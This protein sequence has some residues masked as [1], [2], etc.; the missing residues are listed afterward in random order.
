MLCGCEGAQ[1]AQRLLG[2]GRGDVCHFVHT[3]AGTDRS[4]TGPRSEPTFPSADTGHRPERRVAERRAQGAVRGEGRRGGRH[5]AALPVAAGSARPRPPPEVPG[6]ARPRNLSSR[7]R[8]TLSALPKW[9]RPAGCGEVGLLGRA[10]RGAGV[11]AASAPAP[12]RL[13]AAVSPS[14]AGPV[15]R[16]GGAGWGVSGFGPLA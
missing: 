2:G 10:F 9:R 4:R 15:W 8:G 14:A 11:P 13:R 12:L 6:P 7:S 5:R 16:A 1:P 3:A